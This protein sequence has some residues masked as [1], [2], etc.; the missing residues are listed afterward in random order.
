M[1]A[2]SARRGLMS[3]AFAAMVGA[4]LMSRLPFPDGNTVLELVRL[5]TPPVFYGIKWT[6]LVMLFTTPY[7]GLSLLLSLA[8]IFIGRKPTP[9]VG[10]KL[11]PYPEPAM[12]DKLFL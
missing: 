3:V 7:I 2:I 8:Y 4:A 9:A 5:N 11:P 1:P 6:Y 12:R 10:G